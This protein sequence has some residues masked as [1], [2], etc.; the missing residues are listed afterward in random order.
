MASKKKAA[1]A[2]KP[3]T[4]R[5]RSKVKDL[6]AKKAGSVKGGILIGLNQASP[7]L[8]TTVSKISP[9][10]LKLGDGSVLKIIT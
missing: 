10:A 1:K 3:R 5:A 4:K 8:G 9:G 7:Q 2:G 6:T